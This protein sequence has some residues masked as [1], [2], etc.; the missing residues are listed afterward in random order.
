MSWIAALFHNRVLIAAVIAW[1][2]AQL[3]KAILY[4]VMHRRF[5]WHRLLGDGGMPS[6]HSATVTAAATACAILYGLDSGTF[7]LSLLLAF[8]TCHDAMN[9]RREIGKQAAV[10]KELAKDKES[11]MDIVLKEFVGH[12]P[13]QVVAGILLG[14]AVGL[15]VSLL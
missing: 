10:I 12:T 15:L 11:E 14:L 1:T 4:A 3:L 13:T 6:S 2:V 8:V 7:A 9:S 5:D